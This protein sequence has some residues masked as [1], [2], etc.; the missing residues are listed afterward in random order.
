MTRDELIA[1]LRRL[2]YRLPELGIGP[3]LA[4]LT[5]GE[6]WGLYA[7]LVRLSNAG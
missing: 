4:A 6:L 3:D 1:E 5:I 7:L 2:A